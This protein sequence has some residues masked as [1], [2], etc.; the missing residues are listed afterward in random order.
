MNVPCRRRRGADAEGQSD[1][2]EKK[3]RAREQDETR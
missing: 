1:D 3:D 2:G